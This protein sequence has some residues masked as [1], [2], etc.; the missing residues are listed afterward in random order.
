MAARYGDGRS[1]LDLALDTVSG[2]KPGSWESV[3][4]LAMLAIE[5]RARP[6]GLPLLDAARSSASGLLAGS[7]QSARALAWIARAERELL[8]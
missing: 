6:E 7:W 2:L 8:R 5:A 1:A 4:A 3:E